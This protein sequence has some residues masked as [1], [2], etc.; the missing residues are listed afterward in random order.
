MLPS[1]PWS[2]CHLALFCRLPPAT[3]RFLP[4]AP[5]RLLTSH[6]AYPKMSGFLMSHLYSVPVPLSAAYSILLLSPTEPKK[7]FFY[8]TYLALLLYSSPLIPLPF[9]YLA[10]ILPTCSCHPLYSLH[11]L[12]TLQRTKALFHSAFCL[13]L[14]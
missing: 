10:L 2:V 9:F 11:A 4:H 14:A 1:V 7:N 8:S 6:R 3:A 13:P 5:M 12:S